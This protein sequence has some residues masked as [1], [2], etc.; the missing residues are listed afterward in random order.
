MSTYYISL[1]SHP[2]QL[3]SQPSFTSAA[4]IFVCTAGSYF[5]IVSAPAFF[6]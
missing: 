6:P 4:A 1:V 5:G 3:F 2:L